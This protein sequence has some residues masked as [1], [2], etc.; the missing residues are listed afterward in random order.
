MLST[1]EYNHLMKNWSHLKDQIAEMQR[2]CMHHH[3]LHLYCEAEKD[4]LDEEQKLYTD[5][6]K[7]I[8]EEYQAAH[9]PESP[10]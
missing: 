9:P 8:I 2:Q 6:L 4:R 5:N 1:N 3:K 7:D 10:M